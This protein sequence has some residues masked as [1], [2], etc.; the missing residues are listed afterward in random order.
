GNESPNIGCSGADRWSRPWRS[1]TSDR[2]SADARHARLVA[3]VGVKTRRL[4]AL[5]LSPFLSVGAPRSSRWQDTI[6]Q[7]AG[8]CRSGD[9]R[10]GRGGAG[11]NERREPP[12]NL[13]RPFST[14]T[15]GWRAPAEEWRGAVGDPVRTLS[16][17]TGAG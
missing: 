13:L 12:S 11:G 5:G 4:G 10:Q 14:K 2:R 17:V 1:A 16:S 8:I 15:Q 9:D 6:E 7:S 3:S